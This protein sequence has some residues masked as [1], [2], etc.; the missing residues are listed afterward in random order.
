MNLKTL[1]VLIALSLPLAG[2]G[3]KGPLVLPQKPVPVEESMP[4]EAPPE[5]TDATAQA[6]TDADA[7]VDADA[8][9]DADDDAPPPAEPPPTPLR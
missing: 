2:C 7:T 1:A 9:A 8:D 5:P 3:N 6:I 4:L